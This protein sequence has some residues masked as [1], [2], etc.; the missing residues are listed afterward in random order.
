MFHTYMS[1]RTQPDRDRKLLDQG[2]SATIHRSVESKTRTEHRKIADMTDA[3]KKVKS[4]GETLSKS[5]VSST[6]SAP[7]K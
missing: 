6:T 1:A 5:F 4:R 7:Y 2:Y 3:M